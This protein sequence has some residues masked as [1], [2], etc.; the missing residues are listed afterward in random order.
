MNHELPP[1]S[2]PGGA[3]A[4]L[5]AAVLLV[6]QS[7]LAADKP[8]SGQ[9]LTKEFCQACHFFEGSDQAGTVGPPL[10][11]MKARFP[12]R[13]RMYDLIDDPHAAIKPYTM[14]PPFG[15]NGLLTA[16]EINRIIDYLY[17]L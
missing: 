5:F 6:S 13:K 14:M 3:A 1:L 15:R 9:D 12:D 17:T 11:A 16:D 10:V 7:G 4:V 8:K 2:L